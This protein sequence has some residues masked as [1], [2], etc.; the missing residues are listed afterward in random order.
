MSVPK[1]RRFRPRS[2]GALIVLSLAVTAALAAP[3]SG[4]RTTATYPLNTTLKLKTIRLSSGPQ[5]I[6]VLQLSPGAVPDLQPAASKF[7]LRKR[8]SAMSQA[9]NA[10]AGMNGDF[11][12]NVWPCIVPSVVAGRGTRGS[13]VTVAYGVFDTPSHSA[14]WPLLAAPK[15]TLFSRA[16]FAE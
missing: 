14:A 3:A 4:T 9:A 11:G 10:L 2:V 8:T 12:T 7:P 6:R 15:N 16:E 5:E 13:F 1:R